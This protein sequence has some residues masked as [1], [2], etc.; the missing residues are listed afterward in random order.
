MAESFFYRNPNGTIAM[1]GNHFVM[2]TQQQFEECCCD[3]DDCVNCLH[4][5][6]RHFEMVWPNDWT[7]TWGGS[8]GLPQGQHTIPAGTYR[9]DNGL[10]LSYAINDFCTGAIEIGLGGGVSIVAYLIYDNARWELILDDK[11]TNIIKI[12]D[13]LADPCLPN[14]TYTVVDFIG[15]ED[16]GMPSEITVTVDPLPPEAP[17]TSLNAENMEWGDFNSLEWPGFGDLEYT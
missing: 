5:E 12:Y 13:G 1:Q 7:F 17:N 10:T 16:A 2:L 15:P 11:D 3:D 9:S 14:G 6:N 4:F 8:T